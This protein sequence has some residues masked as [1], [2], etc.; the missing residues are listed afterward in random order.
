MPKHGT[1]ETIANPTVYANSAASEWQTTSDQT[2]WTSTKTEYDP[3]P[4]G[5]KVPYGSR[6]SKPMWNTS[7]IKTAM[8]DASYAWEES[9]TGYWFKLSDG[10]NE[11]VFPIAGYVD[12][13]SDTF[14]A[15]KNTIRAAIWYL[16]DSSSSKYHLNIRPSEGTYQFGST[17]A[18]RGCYVRCGVDE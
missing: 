4:P 1:A 11:L 2:R 12:E 16:S 7:N 3:C 17:S 8:T 18:A 15:Y 6:G 14:Y 13:G 10:A 5:Y 9:T